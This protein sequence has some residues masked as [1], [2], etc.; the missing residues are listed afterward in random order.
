MLVVRQEVVAATLY[1]GCEVQGVGQ[2]V[3]VDAADHCRPVMG[4]RCQRNGRQPRPREGPLIVPQQ[5]AVA[6]SA[7]VDQALGPRQL[8]DDKAM[9]G[10]GNSG[11]VGPGTLP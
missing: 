6:R 8:A 7:G 1:G 9:S 2:S 11:E 3:V 10:R 5:G 4:R